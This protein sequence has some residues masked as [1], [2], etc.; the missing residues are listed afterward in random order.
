M[1]QLIHSRYCPNDNQM[2]GSSRVAGRCRG[3]IL[4]SSLRNSRSAKNDLCSY[5]IRL[6]RHVLRR[7]QNQ[8]RYLVRH[9][10]R[11]HRCCSEAAR[12][13][14]SRASCIFAGE[15]NF[16]LSLTRFRP[17]LAMLKAGFACDEPRKAVRN[18]R[19]TLSYVSA[20]LPLRRHE[21]RPL[22]LC[23]GKLLTL[24][25]HKHLENLHDILLLIPWQ[26]GYLVENAYEFTFRTRLTPDLFC[27]SPNKF[28][29]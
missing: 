24:T 12:D 5:R 14:K 21:A 7:V 20:T 17:F 18:E 25:L 9:V 22:L 29:D 10:A 27:R 1:P 16:A 2:H 28:L 19:I 23:G 8:A 6:D 4:C 26:F 11:L 13:L 15:H 3:R